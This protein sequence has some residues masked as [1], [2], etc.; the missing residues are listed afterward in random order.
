MVTVDNDPWVVAENLEVG[1]VSGELGGRVAEMAAVW[2][3]RGYDRKC[4]K[5]K[6]REEGGREK[7]AWGDEE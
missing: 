7:E 6:Q 2:S 4:E 5:R 1:V 3:G